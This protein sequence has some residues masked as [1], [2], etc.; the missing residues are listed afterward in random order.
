MD[1]YLVISSDGHAGLPPER[2]RDYLD[3]KYREAFDVALPIQIEMTKRSGEALPRSPTSTRSGG[4]GATTSSRAPG[5]HDARVK[6]LDGDGIAARGPVPRRHHRDELAA[7][8]RGLSLPA[9]NVVPELQW[10]GAR[11][12]NRWLRRVRARWRPSGASASRACP[13]SGTSTQAVRGGALGARARARRRSCSRACGASSR[14]SP[15]EV[16]PALGGLPGPRRGRSTSTR[17]RRRSED[18][19]GR[20]PPT[21]GAPLPPGAMGI[22]V[23]RGRVVDDVRPLTF[24]LWGGV[25]ERFPRLKVAITEGTTV[26]VPEYLDCSTS[27]TRRRTT[28]QKLG[29]YRSHLTK[30]P[31]VLRAQRDARR[32]VHVAA[33]GGA[34]P[35][36]R[37]RQ[38]HVGQR[39]P[40]S[41][42][43]AGR[44][45]RE[46][47]L[48]TLPRPARAP[49]SPRCSAATPRAFYGFDA[50]KLAPL[51][52]RIGPEKS[53]FRQRD[54]GQVNLLTNEAV[55]ARS[56]KLTVNQ[57]P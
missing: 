32:V 46:Q 22:Y 9:E 34:A 8:R 7:L 56:N 1:R 19:F 36:D 33:R 4:A 50:E 23:S 38:H 15:P 48:E 57:R 44:V 52:A 6:V 3:P 13:R 35:R 28:R 16:R 12:H 54:V 11:A 49:R 10:A 51:V 27:A 39:L 42:G 21:G 55:R 37:R 14:L 18:Y 26:W 41:R 53:A 24:M 5:I 2:Y 40:A 20:S 29:D 25:F 47:M 31:R 45:T 43:H 30:P 17:A